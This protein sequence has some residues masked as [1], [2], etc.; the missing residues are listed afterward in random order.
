MSVIVVEPSF[1]ALSIRTV[2]GT[3]FTTIDVPAEV[4]FTPSDTETLIV[5]AAPGQL[6]GWDYCR[7]WWV[8]E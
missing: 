6:A 2:G 4:V 7:Y 5:V 3:L 1:P 8:V